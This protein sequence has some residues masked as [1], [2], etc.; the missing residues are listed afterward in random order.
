MIRTEEYRP[1]SCSYI[2]VFAYILFLALFTLLYHPF[3]LPWQWILVNCISLSCHCEC[4]NIL[5]LFTTCLF[6]WKVSC[7]LAAWTAVKSY[8]QILVLLN[9]WY[10]RYISFSILSPSFFFF[11][12]NYLEISVIST[13]APG[14]LL[15][16]ISVL[17]SRQGQ[18]PPGHRLGAGPGPERPAG[19]ERQRHP[20]QR[21]PTCRRGGRQALG[22]ASLQPGR[23]QE[24]RRGATPQQEVSSRRVTAL[25]YW[26]SLQNVSSDLAKSQHVSLYVSCRFANAKW[27][28]N[29]FTSLTLATQSL[30]THYNERKSPMCELIPEI[31]WT[32]IKAAVLNFWGS[33]MRTRRKQLQRPDAAWKSDVFSQHANYKILQGYYGILVR[34]AKKT[35]VSIVP[36]ITNV[37][38]NEFFC[39][40]KVIVC[41]KDGKYEN[42]WKWWVDNLLLIYAHV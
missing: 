24:V 9:Y 5:H 31:T 1:A 28:P 20:D 19:P 40:K 21:R 2:Q 15:S 32:V 22:Q 27:Q 8:Y 18:G 29:A 12:F 38:K 42:P 41:C 35:R 17:S 3:L 16:L 34:D 11:L 25:T 26:K 10:T 6:I 33:S 23:L 4:Y 37:I 30:Q 36:R 7:V 14:S 13:F 39:I